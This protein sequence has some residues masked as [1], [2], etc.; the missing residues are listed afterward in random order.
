MHEVC[1]CVCVR[2]I[3]WQNGDRE[4]PSWMRQYVSLDVCTQKTPSLCLK[5]KTVPKTAMDSDFR[6]SAK[7]R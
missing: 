3:I 5:D 7:K 6:A 4:E 1:V 2:D